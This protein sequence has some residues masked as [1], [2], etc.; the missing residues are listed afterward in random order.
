[1]TFT[2]P[3]FPFDT[4]CNSSP[5][6]HSRNFQLLFLCTQTQ[7]FFLCHLP[8]E[9]GIRGNFSSTFNLSPETNSVTEHLTF[10]HF[11]YFSLFIHS[12]RHFAHNPHSGNSYAHF[13]RT[14]PGVPARKQMRKMLALFQSLVGV[15]DVL[16]CGSTFSNMLILI[17]ET[18]YY[19]PF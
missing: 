6:M 12:H 5:L 17:H 18:F 13:C 9:I 15:L 7:N 2:L 14:N 11:H 4:H 8:Y 19:N 1:M 3:K 10:L 16:L